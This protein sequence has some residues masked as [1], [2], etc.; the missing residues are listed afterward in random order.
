MLDARHFI[1]FIDHKPITFAFQQKRDKCSPRQLNHLD[2]TAQL[3]HISGQDNVVDDALSRIESVTAPPSHEALAAAQNSDDELRTLL[4]AN[5]ALR[6][7]KQPITRYHRLHL[8]RYVCRKTSA[9]HYSSITT[10]SV[11]VRPRSVAPRHESNS[12]AGST[13]YLV[14][15][16]TEGR[17]TWARACQ[18]C[19]LSKDSCHT[20]TPLGDSTPPSARFLHVHTDLV[21]PLR[22]SA[23]YI[24]CLTSLD[25]H[26]HSGHHSR[27]RG[28]R[29]LDRLDI[30][31][32][33]PTDQGRQFESQLFHSLTKLCGIKLSRTTAHH[34]AANGLVKCFHCTLKAAII[35]QRHFPSSF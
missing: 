29:P 12:E 32:R 14:A 8:L 26:P 28:T 34:P 13:A 31:F 22:T 17:R 30:P 1:F 35:G 19:Q 20:V 23:G 4:T 16:H 18:A 21:G 9:V 11:P 3:R 15:R 27:N 33:L 6:L 25:G 7:E 2:F 24:C 5:N 10:P